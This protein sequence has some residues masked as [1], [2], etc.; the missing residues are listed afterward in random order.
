MS[1]LDYNHICSVIEA[2]ALKI[3]HRNSCKLEK[4]LNNLKRKFGIPRV[5][6]LSNDD[7]IFKY[8][9]RALTETEKSVLARGLRFCLPPKDVDKYDVKCS[10]E[11]LYRDL[12]K[13][14]LPLTDENHDQLKSKLKN[15]SYSY[16]YSYDFSKQKNILSKQGHPTSIFGNICS[17]DDLRPRIFGTFVLKLLACL[18]LLGFSNI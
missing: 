3:K 13:L 14:D 2:K 4:K 11:L 18:P 16:I 10:F 15:I 12:I 6:N 17:E 1:P 9:H 7:I 5:S 8:S